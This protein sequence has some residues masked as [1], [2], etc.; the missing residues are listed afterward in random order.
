[1]MMSRAPLAYG[2]RQMSAQAIYEMTRRSFQSFM[3]V[4]CS[5]HRC[6]R[7]KKLISGRSGHFQ[8]MLF[9]PGSMETAGSYSGVLDALAQLQCRVQAAAAA[10]AMDSVIQ[11][12][13]NN[14]C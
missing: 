14:E 3:T 11:G 6:D 12:A 8:G 2:R 10:A 5:A 13:L 7:M 9:A 1:M 4:K